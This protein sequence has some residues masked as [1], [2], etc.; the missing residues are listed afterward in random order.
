[1]NKYGRISLFMVVICLGLSFFLNDNMNYPGIF[2]L[3]FTLLSITGIV[4][5]ALSKKW[6]TIII[7]ISLNTVTWIFFSL[8]IFAIGFGEA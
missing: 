3:L 4:F 6:S 2:L 1:M 5:A 7:G 8:L